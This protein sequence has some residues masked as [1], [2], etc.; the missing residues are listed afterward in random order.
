MATLTIR[1]LDDD[2]RDFLR[3]QAATHGQSMEAE[4]REIL[5]RVVKRRQTKPG[6]VFRRIHSRFMDVG[7]ADKLNIPKRTPTP[8]PVTFDE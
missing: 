2:V 1:N 7:G 5:V 8:E 3:Q 4:V 6:D